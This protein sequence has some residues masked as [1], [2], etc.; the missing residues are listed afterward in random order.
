MAAAV[1]SDIRGCKTTPIR[2]H[3]PQYEL[4]P[5][6]NNSEGK[7]CTSC[8]E[9]GALFRKLACAH[10][11]RML[12]RVQLVACYGVPQLCGEVC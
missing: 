11:V 3:E 5:I 4:R 1:P 9:L 12:Q 2:F 7:S 10:N 6:M 8:N